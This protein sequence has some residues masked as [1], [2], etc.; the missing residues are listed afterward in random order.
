MSPSHVQFG[1]S[2]GIRLPF[3]VEIL[4][5]ATNP[6]MHLTEAIYK[7]PFGSQLLYK[8]VN[9]AVLHPGEHHTHGVLEASFVD[10]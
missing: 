8:L 3:L 4:E 9:G 10:T 5:I 7:P 1:I 2:V 6:P